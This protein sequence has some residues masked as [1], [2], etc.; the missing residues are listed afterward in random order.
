MSEIKTILSTDF[1]F[2]EDSDSTQQQNYNT[3]QQKHIRVFLIVYLAYLK[4]VILKKNLGFDEA[5]LEI[6]YVVSIE[7][8]LLDNAIGTKS[9]FEEIVAASGIVKS[10]GTSNYLKVITRGEGLLPLLQRRHE[11]SEFPLNSYFLLANIHEDYIQLTLN[12]VVVPGSSEVEAS[13]IVIKDKIISIENIYDSLCMN[14]WNC[15]V[16]TES[17]IILCEYHKCQSIY[18]V[19]ELF[20]FDA[21]EDF[22]KSLKSYMSENVSTIQ[23]TCFSYTFFYSSF[24]IFFF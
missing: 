22:F 20:S 2:E 19:Q 21:R 15:V 14:V 4:D 11:G 5:E 23:L 16:Q 6:G 3:Q 7:R 12:K 1:F 13:S 24:C 18:Q 9:E 10:E 8:M 17:L